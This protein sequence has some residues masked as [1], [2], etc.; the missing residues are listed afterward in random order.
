MTFAL[1]S[2]YSIRHRLFEKLSVD[3]PAASFARATSGAL[4]GAFMIRIGNSGYNHRDWIGSFYPP[5]MGPARYLARYGEEFDLCELAGAVHRTP[6]PDEAHRILDESEGRLLFTV[7]APRGLLEPFRAAGEGL[8]QVGAGFLVSDGPVEVAGRDYAI[9]PRALASG[10]MDEPHTRDASHARVTERAIGR[11]VAKR[12]ITYGRGGEMLEASSPPHPPKL[13]MPSTHSK[14]RLVS[15]DP[16]PSIDGLLAAL[17]EGLE[18]Y[19]SA[20]RF[21]GLVLPLPHAIAATESS[22]A[23]IARYCGRLED[24]PLLI[25]PRDASWGEERVVEHLRGLGVGFV[26]ADGPGTEGPSFGP[27]RGGVRPLPARRHAPF[28]PVTAPIAYVRFHGR[29]GETRWA[30]G[31]ARRDYL[32][33]WEEL[34]SWLPSLRALASRARDL[35]VVFNNPWR[36][37]AIENARM[38]RRLMGPGDRRDESTMRSFEERRSEDRDEQ[39]SARGRREDRDRRTKEV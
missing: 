13:A 9:A 14:H 10:I 21:G 12:A 11:G 22:L 37:R 33:S 29:D 36:G 8:P 38:L 1:F 25:E 24:L 35:C 15:S 19:A 2:L 23:T 26:L 4:R 17:R 39:K 16:G 32:Y 7:L 31:A 5:D 30:G 18:P 6:G 27:D 3:A 28:A 34:V 20:G